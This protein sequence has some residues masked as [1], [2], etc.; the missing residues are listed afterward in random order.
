MGQRDVHHRL[1]GRQ[2]A[3]D[4]SVVVARAVEVD[5]RRV[6]R[7]GSVLHVVTWAVQQQLAGGLGDGHLGHV[8]QRQLAD[9]LGHLDGYDVGSGQAGLAHAVEQ[10]LQRLGLGGHHG[11]GQ[12]GVTGDGEEARRVAAVHLNADV[13]VVPVG[14][15][16]A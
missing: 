11:P 15:E 7:A 10:G 2:D 9:Q 16:L 3:Q 6:Q 4:G 14:M 1:A 5:T 13:V 8:R 12:L